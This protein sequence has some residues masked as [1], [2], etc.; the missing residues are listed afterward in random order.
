MA[1]LLGYAAR[2]AGVGVGWWTLS[3]AGF[4]SYWMFVFGLMSMMFFGLEIA[5]KEGLEA[6]FGSAAANAITVFG[7][8]DYSAV[9][10]GM[11]GGWI[12]WGVTT[13]FG[14]VGYA[15]LFVWYQSTGVS[16]VRSTTT[17]L[18]TCVVLAFDF[19]PVL[20]IAPW[21][22]LWVVYLNITAM[23]SGGDAAA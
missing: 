11:E 12:F 23:F 3:I 19:L 13:L 17:L 22:V 10:P 1:R 9:L 18:L 5:D 21:M 8:I 6:L 15:I 14:A 4:C 7:L 2:G 16:F 20:H